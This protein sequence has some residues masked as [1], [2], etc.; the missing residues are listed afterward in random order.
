MPLESNKVNSGWRITAI[1]FI[2][3]FLLETSIFIIG[4]VS[5]AHE[6]RMDNYCSYEVCEDNSA[7][8]TYW[9]DTKWGFYDP[10]SE[11]CVCKKGNDVLKSVYVGDVEN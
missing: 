3:L 7:L 11:V 5:I 8:T 2:I 1:I 6:E 9:E 10:D 4:G